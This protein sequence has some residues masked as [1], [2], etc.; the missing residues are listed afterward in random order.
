MRSDLAWILELLWPRWL[1]RVE[2][3]NIRM[4]RIRHAK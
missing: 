1:P 3:V 4:R 2:E